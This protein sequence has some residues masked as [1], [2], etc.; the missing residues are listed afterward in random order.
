[1]EPEL[2][3]LQRKLL[4]NHPNWPQ[5]KARWVAMGMLGMLGR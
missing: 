2:K 1:M 4:E 5:Q 3:D